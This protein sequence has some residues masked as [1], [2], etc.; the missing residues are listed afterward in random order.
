MAVSRSPNGGVVRRSLAGCWD[1]AHFPAALLSHEIV[2][3]LERLNSARLG[4]E[5]LSRLT[6]RQRTRAV[7]AALEAHH[8]GIT[9]C[10]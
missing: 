5:A 2:K 4:K 3:E 7:K 6:P 8:A 9:R 1:M 10:C